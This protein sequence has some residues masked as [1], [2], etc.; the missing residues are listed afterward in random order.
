M[1][2]SAFDSSA[3]SLPTARGA[4]YWLLKHLDGTAVQAHRMGRHGWPNFLVDARWSATLVDGMLWRRQHRQI[5]QYHAAS[6]R[7]YPA[8]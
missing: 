5:R 4:I 8:R 1:H 6:K 2:L 3:L 7:D